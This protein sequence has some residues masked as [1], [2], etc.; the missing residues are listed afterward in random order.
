MALSDLFTP[1]GAQY[2]VC[3]VCGAK[4]RRNALAYSGHVRGKQHQDA[5]TTDEE[6]ARPEQEPA[7]PEQEPAP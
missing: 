3:K 5:L 2:A 6:H 7:R 4:I 1:T